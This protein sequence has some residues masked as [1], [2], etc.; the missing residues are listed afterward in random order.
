MEEVF[1]EENEEMGKPQGSVLSVTLFDIKCNN[2]VKNIN[3]GTNCAL[4]VDDFLICYR[5]RNMNY[6]ERQLRICLDK[7]PQMDHGE[8][9]KIFKRK[10][11]MHSL[12]Q[13]T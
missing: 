2:I 7:L 13:P 1:S 6:I 10:K 3:S 9:I 11:Q 8:W 5:A 12:L 4:Y